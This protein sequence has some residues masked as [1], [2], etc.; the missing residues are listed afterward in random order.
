MFVIF[1]LNVVMVVEINYS[2]LQYFKKYLEI[3]VSNSQVIGTVQYVVS[4]KYVVTRQ[5]TEHIVPQ[6][7][8]HGHL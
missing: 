5:N 3:L 1:T 8:H 2:N 4:I 6:Y 7:S